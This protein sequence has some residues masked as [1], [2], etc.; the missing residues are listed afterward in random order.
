M[1]S[2]MFQHLHVYMCINITASI[3]LRK[4]YKF[5]WKNFM[6]NKETSELLMDDLPIVTETLG[7]TG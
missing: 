4:S 5:L 2:R 7:K 3:G 6:N 1:V